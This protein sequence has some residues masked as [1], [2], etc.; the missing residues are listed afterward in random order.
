LAKYIPGKI[1]SSI[2]ESNIV[3][4][5]GYSLKYCLFISLIAQLLILLS[6]FLIGLIGIFLFDL[7]ILPLYLL[8]IVLAI[9]II[10]FI[11]FARG[12]S[13]PNL[14]FKF[15]P[16]FLKPLGNRKIKPIADLYFLYMLQWLVLGSAY[17]LFIKAIGFDTG[18]YPILVQ[19]LANNI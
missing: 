18:L 4:G 2:G 19:P 12:F 7:V 9:I 15:I 16:K 10:S 5:Y 3:S 13:I 17:Y 8:Y 14:D 11:I 1:W 6:G